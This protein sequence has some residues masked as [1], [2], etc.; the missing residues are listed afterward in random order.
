MK[1]KTVVTML[2]VTAFLAGNMAQA[3]LFTDNFDRAD[4]ASTLDGS[5]IGTDYV[6]A[7]NGGGFA[8]TGN[9][10]Q[11]K[12]PDVQSYLYNTQAATGTTGGD[13]FSISADF[14]FNQPTVPSFHL[15][16]VWNVQAD[17][18]QFYGIRMGT[19]GYQFI[20]AS[21]GAL[22]GLASGS[23]L[24][25]LSVGSWYTLTVNSTATAYSFDFSLVEKSSGTT[26]WSGNSGTGG[27]AFNDGFGGLYHAS[28]LIESTA[29]NLA[30][31][32]IPEPATMALL[33]LAA[34][35]LMG[36]RRLSRC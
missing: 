5:V 22:G 33:G 11:F 15:G 34:T 10:L 25:E 36:V 31:N 28:T 26:M 27:F 17:D 9:E 18:T 24:T 2:A 6:I 29:D 16:L 13:S 19:S 12:A 23:G 3:G 4:T 32:T 14:N 7:G 35:V 21:G 8:V 1:K 20:Q 30:V